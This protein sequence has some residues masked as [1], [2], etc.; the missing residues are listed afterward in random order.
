MPPLL[1]RGWWGSSS[2]T[3]SFDRF[4]QCL[5]MNLMVS[6]MLVLSDESRIL[7]GEGR[8]VRLSTLFELVMLCLLE[9]IASPPGNR[10]VETILLSSSEVAVV[11][12]PLLLLLLLSLFNAALA[13]RDDFFSPLLALG[14]FSAAPPPQG[15]LLAPLAV[16]P[17]TLG[18]RPLSSVSTSTGTNLLGHC[19]G[20]PEYSPLLF[21]STMALAW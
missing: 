3:L 14:A 20:R 10:P 9:L 12:R 17:R 4:W 21:G 11:S 18:V 13:A 1:D 5:R 15:L 7:E 6:S 16:W 8:F 2:W 19:G